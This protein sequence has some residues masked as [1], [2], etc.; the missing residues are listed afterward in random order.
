M[1]ENTVHLFN[2]N[3]VYRD[4]AKMAWE[5]CGLDPSNKPLDECNIGMALE[6][7]RQEYGDILKRPEYASPVE[8]D[9]KHQKANA[10]NYIIS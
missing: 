3:F 1:C 6:Y 5:Y 2:A 7:A 9:E 8:I 4:N 10:V